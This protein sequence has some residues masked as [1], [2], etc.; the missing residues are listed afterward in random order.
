VLS[1]NPREFLAL[2]VSELHTTVDLVAQD[3]ILSDKI[4]I[5]KLLGIVHRL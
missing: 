4:V 1:A 2:A 5:A 3:T